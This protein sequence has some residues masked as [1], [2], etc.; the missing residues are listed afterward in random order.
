[1]PLKFSK[2]NR[3]ELRKLASGQ[4]VTE[5]GITFERLS[6]GDGVYSVN[7]MVDGQ[8]IH[9]VI[10][11][12]SDGTT[13]TQ[14]E[15][16]IEKVKRDAK[17]G[18]LN[19]PKGRKL[20]FSF[21]E[22]GIKYLEKLESEDGKNLRIKHLQMKLHLIPFFGQTPLGKVSSSD[23]EQYKKLRQENNVQPS[24]INRELATISHLFNKAMEWQWLDK[25]PA[26]IKRLKENQSKITYLTSEQ[27][28][29]HIRGCQK[30]PE[31][32]NLPF[33]RYWFRNSHASYGDF[34]YQIRKY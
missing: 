10:G 4:K 26:S 8:R 22:A 1:M 16:F 34:I 9:R 18:R 17:D 27:A 28:R 21:K 25:R 31:S 13:R 24:T 5:H 3:P 23:I 20:T 12:E 6:N 11:R 29:P 32:A 7:I 15:E 19:L 33:Y 14:A 30:R 2:L